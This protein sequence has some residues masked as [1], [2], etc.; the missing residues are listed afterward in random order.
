MAFA[1]E[2]AQAFGVSTL[3]PLLGSFDPKLVKGA[4][5]AKAAKKAGKKGA[6]ATEAAGSGE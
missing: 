6:K 3:A 5:E 2:A 1:R 4:N